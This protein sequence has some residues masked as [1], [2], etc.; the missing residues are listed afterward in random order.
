MF[1]HAKTVCDYLIVAL[2]DDPTI[3]RPNNKIKPIQTLAERKL[4]L[5]AIRWVDEVVTYS[6]E[7]DFYELLKNTPHDIR[8]L[9]ADYEGIDHIGQDLGI[10]VH[11]HKRGHEYSTTRLKFKIRD[12]LRGKRQ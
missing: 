7:T 11:Y 2:Q 5:S 3:D 4:I 1:E 6:T 8:I 9:G 12:S 10:P